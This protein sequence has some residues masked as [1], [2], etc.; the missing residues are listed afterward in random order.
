MKWVE[1]DLIRIDET[2]IIEDT[3]DKNSQINLVEDNYI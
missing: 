1:N 3:E 2:A